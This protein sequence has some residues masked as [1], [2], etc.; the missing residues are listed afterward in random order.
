M[1]NDP[2]K[3][4]FDDLL[5]GSTDI[6]SLLGAPQPTES[7]LPLAELPAAELPTVDL[8]IAELSPGLGLP[9]GGLLGETSTTESQEIQTAPKDAEEEAAEE[10]KE[11]QPGPLAVLLKKFD[12]YTSMLALSFLAVCLGCLFLWIEWGRYG[13]DTKAKAAKTHSS[14]PVSALRVNSPLRV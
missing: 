6:D 2:H 13:R 12:V 4:E 5:S 14:M 3:S 8:P 7:L 9:P 11:K 1:S 10:E